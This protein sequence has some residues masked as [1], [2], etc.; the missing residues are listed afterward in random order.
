MTART[1]SYAESFL[2]YFNVAFARTESQK[3]D[4]GRIRYRV[5][6]EEFGYETKE[7]NPGGIE[8]DEFDAQSMHCLVTHKSSDTPAGCVRV[9]KCQE[10]G[11]L[12]FEKHCGDSLDSGFFQRNP[13]PRE[14][15]CE[16]SRLA[17]DALFRRR[18]G[19]QATRFGGVHVSDISQQEQR[20]FPLIAV[21]CFLAATA[22]TDLADCNNGFAMMEPFLPRLLTR[23]GISFV[24]VGQDTDYHGLRAPYFLTT[25]DAVGN[26]APELRELYDAIHAKIKNEYQSV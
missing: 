5:Y 2:T 18:S 1:K 6:C 3:K 15:M 24:K 4:V 22:L 16:I 14:N 7:A 12:P 21:S 26:M 9:I 17:V 25:H 20:T 19:E 10:H 23:S 13:M 11:V 8:C